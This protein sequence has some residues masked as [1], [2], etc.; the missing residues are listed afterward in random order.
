MGNN[1]LFQIDSF[2]KKN[3]T[4]ASKNHK[5]SFTQYVYVYEAK[6]IFQGYV[7]HSHVH[8]YQQG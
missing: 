5:I 8:T 6:Y 4:L 7:K 3:K 1:A 2:E